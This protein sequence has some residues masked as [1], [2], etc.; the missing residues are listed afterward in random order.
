MILKDRIAVVTGAGSGIGRAGAMIMG[1]EGATVV[2]ADRDRAA[3]E[4]V[5]SD[6]RE[7][8]GRAEAVT[9]DVGNDTAVEALI[10][11]TL[12]RHGRIDI[13]HN[14]AGIQVGGTLTEVGVDG[15]DASWRINVRAQFVSAKTVM[16]AMIAQGGG[17]IL[18]TA[19]NSGVFYDREMIAYATSKHAV[20]AMTRQMSLDYARH[21][22]RINALCPGWVDTPFNEPFIA[23][24][25][26]REAIENYVRTKIPMGR[27]ASADEI[28][29][30]I[31]FLVSDRSS[32]MTGQALVVDGGE[33]I[34]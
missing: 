5:A 11:G 34:G 33:S 10:V 4:A 1:R 22:V 32:F 16:P 23:Q 25:G 2:I 17:V 26:G 13:L 18:N 28:A 7:A 14:H 24:M 19:S 3:G 29:E 6:I 20:V 8:G 30:A 12:G 31:L 21:N 27:W 15:M 9:T